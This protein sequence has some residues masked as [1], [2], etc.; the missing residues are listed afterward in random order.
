MTQRN[1]SKK[2]NIDINTLKDTDMLQFDVVL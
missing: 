2:L 1:K